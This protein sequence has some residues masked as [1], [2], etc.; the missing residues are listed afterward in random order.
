MHELP[1]ENTFP[2]YSANE[3]SFDKIAGYNELIEHL[4]DIASATSNYHKKLMTLG[5]DPSMAS[6]LTLQ[7]HEAYWKGN[8]EVG[9]VTIVNESPHTHE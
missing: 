3:L 9:A 5:F 4:D 2:E 1:D 6:T 8:C 7:W